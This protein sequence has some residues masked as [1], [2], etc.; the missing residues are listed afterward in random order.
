MTTGPLFASYFWINQRDSVEHVIVTMPSWVPFLPSLALP[1]LALLGMPVFGIFLIREAKTFES[2]IAAFV[3]AYGTVAAIWIFFPS[4]MIRPV[5]SGENWSVYREMISV[6]RPVCILPCGHIV[7]PVLV[8][9]FLCGENRSHLLW[10]LPVLV[11]GSFCIVATWQHRPI[12]VLIGIAISL[13][14]A[15][16]C[17]RAIATRPGQLPKVP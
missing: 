3:V 1:Y 6:D 14:A 4:E 15:W 2:Y 17:K 5:L 16:I 7:G 8:T 9:Y 11:G 13:C 10:L 12:D